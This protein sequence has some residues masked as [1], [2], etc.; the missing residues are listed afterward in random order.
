MIFCFRNFLHLDIDDSKSLHRS[1]VKQDIMDSVIW[2]ML[3]YQEMNVSAAKSSHEDAED[4]QLVES[5]SDGESE[6]AGE[7]VGIN[8]PQDISSS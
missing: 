6:L 1:V 8:I 4:Y 2:Q 3:P 7:L 5:D